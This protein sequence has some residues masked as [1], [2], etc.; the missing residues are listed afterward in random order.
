M[1]A[2]GGLSLRLRDAHDGGSGQ[3]VTRKT[4][5]SFLEEA[6][7]AETTGSDLLLQRHDEDAPHFEEALH[8]VLVLLLH[9]S[10]TV[11]PVVLAAVRGDLQAIAGDKGRLTEI[12]PERKRRFRHQLYHVVASRCG[13]AMLTPGRLS[14]SQ[15]HGDATRLTG[16]RS[17]KPDFQKELYHD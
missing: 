2:E 6:W 16:A 11:H 1:A 5:V 10:P 3:R 8:V 7:Q 4:R 12:E 9:A 14:I 15:S 17:W 13:T